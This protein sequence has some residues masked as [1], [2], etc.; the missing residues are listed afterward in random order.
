MFTSVDDEQVNTQVAS[1]VLH[2]CSKAHIVAKIR[3][4][5][6]L[7]DVSR[8]PTVSVGL[9]H[10]LLLNAQSAGEVLCPYGSRSW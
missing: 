6:L 5:C 3:A 1:L 8:Q 4:V 2:V 7:L 9:L 10:S